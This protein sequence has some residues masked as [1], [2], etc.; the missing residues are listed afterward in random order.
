MKFSKEMYLRF[1]VK[2]PQV[3]EFIKCFLTVTIDDYDDL[4]FYKLDFYSD[5]CFDNLISLLYLGEGQISFI[6]N[7]V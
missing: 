4:I 3:S 2:Y 7:H 1:D 5:T 6:R